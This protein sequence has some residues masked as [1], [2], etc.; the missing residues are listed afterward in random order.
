[1]ENSGKSNTGQ[2]FAIIGV[3]IGLVSLSVNI[4]QY[5]E[6]REMRANQAEL[7]AL[8][9]NDAKSKLLS[10]KAPANTTA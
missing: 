6:N 4:W 5:V 8:Q 1:M 9:L 3:V 2:Y 7:T 10:A